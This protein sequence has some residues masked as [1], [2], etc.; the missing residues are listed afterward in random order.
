MNQDNFPILQKSSEM[1]NNPQVFPRKCVV[2]G[3]GMN[4]GYLVYDCETVATEADL[5]KFLRSSEP[6]VW[7]D[8]SDDFV[9]RDAYENE[10]YFYTEWEELDDLDELYLADGTPCN[11]LGIPTEESAQK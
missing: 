8:L 9:L 7:R 10:E 2:S 5:I 4:A 11:V 3:V 1:N 6:D